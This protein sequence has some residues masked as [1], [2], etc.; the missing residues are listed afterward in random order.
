MNTLLTCLYFI[1]HK[2]S[3]KEFVVCEWTANTTSLWQVWRKA[4]FRQQSTYF[5]YH[6]KSHFDLKYLNMN[7]N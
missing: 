3:R 5:T 7:Q 6:I 4:Q 1:Q 2:T